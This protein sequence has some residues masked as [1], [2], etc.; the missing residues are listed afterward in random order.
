M[1]KE[2]TRTGKGTSSPAL[3]LV[4]PLPL[5]SLASPGRLLPSLFSACCCRRLSLGPAEQ[6]AMQIT[7]EPVGP[8]SLHCSTCS[9]AQPWA[10]G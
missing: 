3:P 8:S 5:P 10:P 9:Q 1:L 4:S 7:C 2:G 6:A